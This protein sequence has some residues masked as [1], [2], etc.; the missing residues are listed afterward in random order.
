MTARSRRNQI[1]DL[2]VWLFDGSRRRLRSKLFSVLGRLYLQA[3]G[4]HVGIGVTM[5]S[6]P[7][8]RCY[9]SGSL[10]VGN[11]VTILNSLS[12]NRAGI[13]HETVMIVASG[14]KL[15]IGNH[16]GISGA[17][18]D[19]QAPVSIGERVMLGANCSLLTT[20]YHPLD[21][22][23]RFERIEATVRKAPIV[24]EDDVWVGANA[25]ILKGVTIGARSIIGAGSVVTK[26]VAPG[27]VV[28]G[29]PARVV[30]SL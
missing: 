15:A 28:A 17:I 30:K 24:I 22:K 7:Y 23:E 18:I 4:A 14:S 8:C 20:D 26:D 10:R 21:A 27:V 13:I 11:Y 3:L 16:V 1:R 2:I 9:G 25:I 6:L 5:L 12:E 29:N 19:A